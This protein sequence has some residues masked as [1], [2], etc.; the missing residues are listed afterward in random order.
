MRWIFSEIR[1]NS[2]RW[3]RILSLDGGKTWQLHKE[4]SVRRAEP[5]Q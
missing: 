4:M 5:P 2:F 1:N 3:R